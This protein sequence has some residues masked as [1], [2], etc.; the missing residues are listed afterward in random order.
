LAPQESQLTTLA[1]R[2]L[3]ATTAI[4]VAAACALLTVP[5]IA[6]VIAARLD[7][8]ASMVGTYISFLY[9]GASMAALAGGGVVLRY[10]AMRLSQA[11]L[12]ACAAGLALTLVLGADAGLAG[13]VAVGAAALVIGVG[14]GPITPASSHVLAKTTS[15][16]RMALMFSIK[17]T[18]VPAGTALAGL[19]VPPLTVMFGWEVAVVLVA[20]GCIAMA[21]LAQPLREPLDD[22]R[23]RSA[24][25]S[26]AALVTGLALVGR[27][28]PLRTMALVSFVYAGM[29][30]SVSGFIVAYLHTEIGLGLVAAGT[31]LTAANVA[32]VVARISWGSVSDHTGAPRTTLATIG[33]LM[34]GASVVTACFTPSWP[35]VAILA[36]SAALG[37]TAIGWNGVYLSE[38]ARLAPP[39]EAGRATGGCLFFTYVGVVVLPFLFGW[40]QRASGSYALCFLVA[41]G[42]C[43]SVAALLAWGGGRGRV[44]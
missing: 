42:V 35:M 26:P 9:V 10:G 37:A 44:R 33:F 25:L 2:A 5:S 22:D 27:S 1:T 23:D 18:G 41:A 32:G 17:Q 16:E 38:I 13:W 31:A 24:R 4:Q 11:C 15:P 36:V 34:A 7:V 14:Y 28:P 43:A 6:P 40:L 39:G 12:L 29:Q 8:P 30:M 19:V 3:I 21:L 20:V